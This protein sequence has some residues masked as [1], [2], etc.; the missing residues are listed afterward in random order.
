MCGKFITEKH[1]IV[2]R[3]NSLIIKEKKKRYLNG[4]LSIGEGKR[5]SLMDILL[6]HHLQTKDFS[7]EDIREELITF[8][9]AVYSK[10]YITK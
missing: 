9:L 3:E 2:K 8:T 7:E 1:S 4:E 10:T 5:S 6:E